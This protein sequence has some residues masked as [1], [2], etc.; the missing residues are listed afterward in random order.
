MSDS[1]LLSP[2]HGANPCIPICFFCREEKNEVALLG[3]LPGDI[4]AP[5]NVLLDY[6]PCDKCK[7]QFKL[8]VTLIEVTNKPMIENQPEIQQGLYP[9]GRFATIKEEAAKNCF[10]N[11][12]VYKGQIILIDLDLHFFE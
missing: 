12:T 5:K 4:E 7:E 1:I 9:T 10:P 6:V 2:K 8:G 3:K 11:T